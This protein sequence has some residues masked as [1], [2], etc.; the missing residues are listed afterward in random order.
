[1]KRLQFFGAL[2]L[3]VL[4]VAALAQQDNAGS[5]N[6]IGKVQSVYV[7]EARGLYIEK[8]LIRRPEGRELWAEVRVA[9]PASGGVASELAKLPAHVTVDTGDVVETRLVEP[10]HGDVAQLEVNRVIRVVAKFDTLPAMLLGLAG[11]Q[12]VPGLRADAL[13]CMPDET[14]VAA[15]TL[16]P[17]LELAAE[18]R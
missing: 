17:G 1:M 6:Q 7:R 15:Y 13:V 18:P 8:S 4:S 9:Q 5:K 12:A 16:A 2:P 11:S 10:V 14:H 3:A